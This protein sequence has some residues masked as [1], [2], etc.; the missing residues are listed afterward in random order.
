MT[1]EYSEMY[2]TQSLSE[3]LKMHARTYTNTQT[4]NKPTIHLII[5]T[6][7]NF[8]QNPF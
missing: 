4:A 7:G 3:V 6:N 2:F 5:T 1:I 8:F